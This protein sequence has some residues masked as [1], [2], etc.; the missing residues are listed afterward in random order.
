MDGL[1]TLRGEESDLVGRALLAMVESIEQESESPSDAAGRTYGIDWFDQWDRPQRLWLLEQIAAAFFTER[2]P[3]AAAA[4]WEATIDAVFGEVYQ[5]I[6]DEI[7]GGSRSA[8][9]WRHDTLAAYESSSG[10]SAD[11]APEETDLQRWRIVVTQL[12]DRILGL[13]AYQKAELLRDGDIKAASRFL[14]QRGL[15]EDF[16]RRIPPLISDAQAAA[17]AARIRSLVA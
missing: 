14:A 1:R 17:S 11:L 9:S 15:P 6:G 13:P 2:S 7:D 12:S 5:R 8:D 16:L 10:R 4:M 3:P